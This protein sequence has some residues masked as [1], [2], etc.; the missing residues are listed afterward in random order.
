MAC[1]LC[2]KGSED[3]LACLNKNT[4]KVGKIC[5]KCS[6]KEKFYCEECKSLEFLKNSV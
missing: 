4:K 5:K 1:E 6:E 3:V 2:S